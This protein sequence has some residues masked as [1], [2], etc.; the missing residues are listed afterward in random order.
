MVKEGHTKVIGE[1]LFQDSNIKTTT[2]G[3][4]YKRRCWVSNCGF[5]DPASCEGFGF[6]SSW[7]GLLAFW[8]LLKCPYSRHSILY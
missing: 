6:S 8:L 4:A 7:P 3:R 2:T 5:L 1:E